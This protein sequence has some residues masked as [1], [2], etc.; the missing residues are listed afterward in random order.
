ML[1]P[2]F[3]RECERQLISAGYGLKITHKENM[4]QLA[5]FYDGEEIMQFN[6]ESERKVW[7]IILLAMAVHFGQSYSKK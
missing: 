5:L 1:K 7:R 6:G 2:R 3:V 4:C